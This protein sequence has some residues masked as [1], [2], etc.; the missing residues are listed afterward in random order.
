MARIG[1]I[2]GSPLALALAKDKER[3]RG[4]LPSGVRGDRTPITPGSPLS[5]A[6]ERKVA[7]E[8]GLL[9][10]L[11]SSLLPVV[12]Q[13]DPRRTIVDLGSSTERLRRIQARRRGGT[14]FSFGL[15]SEE[16]RITRQTLGGG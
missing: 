4:L 14:S 8:A 3:R 10:S 7:A 11:E 9:T 12:P 13:P 15:L 6:I 2:P 5:L 1:P 16:P